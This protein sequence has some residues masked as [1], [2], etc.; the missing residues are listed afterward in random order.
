MMGLYRK[1]FRFARG[2]IAG[3]PNDGKY[4]LLGLP[5]FLHTFERRQKSLWKRKRVNNKKLH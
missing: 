4:D 2:L 5:A 1:S 3:L